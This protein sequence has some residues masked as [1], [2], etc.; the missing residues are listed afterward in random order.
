MKIAFGVRG[1]QKEKIVPNPS[2]LIGVNLEAS[3]WGGS[4]LGNIKEIQ[5]QIVPVNEGLHTLEYAFG[6]EK[7]FNPTGVQFYVSA[8]PANHNIMVE[9][10]SLPTNQYVIGSPVTFPITI[11]NKG[12][13]S[14]YYNAY[15]EVRSR[16]GSVFDGKYD[17]G[18]GNLEPGEATTKTVSIITTPP[19]GIGLGEKSAK[20][21]VEYHTTPTITEVPFS[22]IS[23]IGTT[24]TAISTDISTVTVG[25]QKVLKVTVT[26]NHND[27]RHYTV[28]IVP[29]PNLGFTRAEWDWDLAPNETKDAEFLFQP[30]SESVGAQVVQIFVN[31]RQQ[32]NAQFLVISKVEAE[33]QKTEGQIFNL[34]T[35]TILIIVVFIAVGIVGYMFIRGRKKVPQGPRASQQIE[36]RRGRMA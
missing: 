4:T 28:T 33:K 24:F 21:Y 15:V 22:V 3:L 9:P 19:N 32:A 16:D 5:A 25:E 11:A 18:N 26:N 31:S 6:D 1:P 27:R 2:E 13:Y 29:D 14:E 17:I 36:S 8:I 10:V 20:V 23:P 12:T 35:N 7:E 30:R 34:T